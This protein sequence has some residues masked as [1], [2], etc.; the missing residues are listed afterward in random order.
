MFIK[1]IIKIKKLNAL[2][3]LMHDPVCNKKRNK[4][5]PPQYPAPYH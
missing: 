2:K 4:Q 5:Y 1:G 3:I